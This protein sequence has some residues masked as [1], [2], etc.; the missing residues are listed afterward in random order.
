[1]FIL[2]ETCTC[3]CEVIEIYKEANLMLV[4]YIGTKLICKRSLCMQLA[5]RLWKLV[6]YVIHVGSPHQSKMRFYLD[7]INTLLSHFLLATT[8][9]HFLRHQM[10]LLSR[11]RVWDGYFLQQCINLACESYPTGTFSCFLLSVCLPS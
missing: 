2:I 4:D 3:L 7:N 5:C 11:W 10:I 8:Q 1:M 6:G 9:L